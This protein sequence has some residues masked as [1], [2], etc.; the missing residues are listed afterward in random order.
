MS[1]LLASASTTGPSSSSSWFGV[2]TL[3]SIFWSSSAAEV[4]DI[5]AP[6]TEA[7]EAAAVAKKPPCHPVLTKILARRW[8]K[9]TPSLSSKRRYAGPH[10][11]LCKILAHRWVKLM[12]AKHAEQPPRPLRILEQ[13]TEEERESLHAAV[14]EQLEWQRETPLCLD[15]LERLY[16]ETRDM[17]LGDRIYRLVALV[18]TNN[19]GKVTGMLLEGF[20]TEEIYNTLFNDDAATA[21]SLFL[22]LVDEAHVVLTEWGEVEQADYVEADEAANTSAVVTADDDWTVVT[23]KSR[24]RQRDLACSP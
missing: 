10:P 13:L 20:S 3:R 9:A 6:E 15:N 5:V 18:E 2:S 24:R 23:A 17:I 4:A 1:I 8:V 12:A 14:V 16:V 22:E 19:P 11:V 21:A 7:L